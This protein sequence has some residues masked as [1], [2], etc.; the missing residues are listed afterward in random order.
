MKLRKTPN[1]A[2]SLAM[3]F[4]WILTHKFIQID[5]PN[6]GY[7]KTNIDDQNGLQL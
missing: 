6:I 3:T 1:L 2:I 7:R 5:N 4:F